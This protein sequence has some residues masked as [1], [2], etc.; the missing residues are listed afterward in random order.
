M[1]VK[2]K[3]K[4]F[5]KYISKKELND[6]TTRLA[7]EIEKNVGSKNPLFVVMLNGAFVFASDFLRKMSFACETIFVRYSSY[8]GMQTTGHV[9]QSAIPEKVNGRHVV[10]IEDIVDTGITAKFLTDFISGNFKT[11]STKFC[12]LLDK[13]ITRQADIEPDYY[14][15]EVD[16]KFLVGYGLDYEGYQRNLRYVGYV[17]K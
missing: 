12:S 7:S 15:F 17:E 5:S 4:Y 3:D 16:N 9:V 2:V 10:V 13:K 6:I 14:G 11:K 1:T 8:C